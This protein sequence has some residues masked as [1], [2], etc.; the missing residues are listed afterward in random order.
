MDDRSILRV[1][2]RVDLS[3]REDLSSAITLAM[4]RATGG[5]TVTVDL[6]GVV[7]IGAAASDVLTTALRQSAAHGITMT[8]IGGGVPVDSPASADRS[9]VSSPG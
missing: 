3:N 1:C 8:I 6:R 2:G 9:P 5:G 7:R 4:L